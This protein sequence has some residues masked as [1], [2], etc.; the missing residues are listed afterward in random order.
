MREQIHSVSS[1]NGIAEKRNMI[2]RSVPVG[3]IV[4]YVV[5]LA[6]TV[7]LFAPFLIIL[8]TSLTGDVEI[9]SRA[10]FKLFPQEWTVEGY[11][12]I[13]TLDPN[14]IN[15][16]S[17]LLVGFFNT[18]WQTLIPLV[19]GLL[20]SAFS[21]YIFSKFR[22][23]GRKALFMVTVLTM[24][25]PMGAFGFV[26]YLFYMK[27]GWVGDAG[28]LPIIIPGLFG[29]AGTVF[30]LRSYFDSAISSEVLEA[31]KIDGAGSFR[32]FFTIVL[33]LAKPALIAQF[34]FGFVGGYNSYSAALL[35][36]YPNKEMWTLQLALSELVSMVSQDGSGYANA[37]CA[38]ALIAM[39]PLILLYVLVQKYFIEGIN[40]GGGKE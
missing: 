20:T 15:G 13:F 26:S 16:V 39:L 4:T 2:R 5:L 17:S 21:A 28:I 22:F 6:Y 10:I 34:L 25:L 3:N 33:P 36:L 8:F 19:G 35:Y 27:L 14:A 24:M 32:I 31:A 1:G 37:Q 23:P 18:M 29:G 40:I 9:G 12:V 38:A 11:E 30:F 7:I